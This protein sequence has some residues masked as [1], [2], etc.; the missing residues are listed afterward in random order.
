M[1]SSSQCRGPRVRD[2]CHAPCANSGYDRKLFSVMRDKVQHFLRISVWQ[3]SETP[4]RARSERSRFFFRRIFNFVRFRSINRGKKT[5]L[6]NLI[7]LSNKQS[8]VNL[9][10]SGFVRSATSSRSCHFLR[11]SCHKVRGSGVLCPGSRTDLAR[12][13]NNEL[14][15]YYRIFGNIFFAN[16]VGRARFRYNRPACLSHRQP[17]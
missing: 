16:E 2:S 8:K 12:R 15:F 5:A 4:V 1:L 7:T 11:K 17:R 14:D 9:Y 13:R 10:R 6:L 3:W